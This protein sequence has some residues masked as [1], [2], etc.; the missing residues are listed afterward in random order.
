MIIAFCSGYPSFAWSLQAFFV[1]AFSCFVN[2]HIYSFLSRLQFYQRRHPRCYLQKR[3]VSRKRGY[4]THQSCAEL[5]CVWRRA[6]VNRRMFSK[7]RCTSQKGPVKTVY[8]L[9][10]LGG[11]TP[12]QKLSYRS[13]VWQWVTPYQ[14]SLRGLSFCLF[15][16]GHIWVV[17]CTLG[18]WQ[19]RSIHMS[20]DGKILLKIGKAQVEDAFFDNFLV[21]LGEAGTG[22]G[23]I[24][25][26]A[27]QNKLALIFEQR[28]DWAFFRLVK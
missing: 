24:A 8:W 28:C 26:R 22:F 20:D 2:P 21:S 5:W 4:R 27:L 9:E 15:T 17:A 14:R 7:F 12:F 25:P 6:C 3:I 10:F 18:W 16:G 11:T 19:L 1:I 23:S 13:L